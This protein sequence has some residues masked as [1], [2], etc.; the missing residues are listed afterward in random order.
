MSVDLSLGRDGQHATVFK[1]AEGTAAARS[2]A[3]GKLSGHLD[4]RFTMC[5]ARQ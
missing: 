5:Q 3:V 2:T 4:D 1:K